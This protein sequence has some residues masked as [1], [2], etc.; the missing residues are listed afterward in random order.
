MVYVLT[1]PLW[2][3]ECVVCARHKMPRTKWNSNEMR[4]RG[5]NSQSGWLIAV[6]ILDEFKKNILYFAAAHCLFSSMFCWKEAPWKVICIN[7]SLFDVFI[8]WFPFYRLLFDFLI[9]LFILFLFFLPSTIEHIEWFFYGSSNISEQI[10]FYTHFFC[11]SG[12]FDRLCVMLSFYY[13]LVVSFK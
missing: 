7:N 3:S 6:N 12:R 5:T 11:C 10:C 13:S 1:A 4:K 8:A 9:I 2:V